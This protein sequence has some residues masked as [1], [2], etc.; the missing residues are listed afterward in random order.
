MRVAETK[1]FSVLYSLEVGSTLPAL[2]YAIN[3]IGSTGNDNLNLTFRVQG[4]E[5]IDL[6]FDIKAVT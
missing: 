6:I 3:L 2:F 1:K 5:K 4:K